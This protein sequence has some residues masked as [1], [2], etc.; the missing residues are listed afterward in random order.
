MHETAHGDC[1][2]SE[3]VFF[4]S[5]PRGK[6]KRIFVFAAPGIRIRVSIAPGFSVGRSNQVSYPWPL[7]ASSDSEYTADVE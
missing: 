3:E 1:T 7:L 4:E 2:D 6:K 5:W